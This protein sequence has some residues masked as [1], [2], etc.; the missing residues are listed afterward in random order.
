MRLRVHARVCGHDCGHNSKPILTKLGSVVQDP[1]SKNLFAVFL[2]RGKADD[3][4]RMRRKF[5]MLRIGILAKNGKCRLS[6]KRY[7]IDQKC[8][9]KANRKSGM[10]FR[11]V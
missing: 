1:K 3:F 7:E 2:N 11:M 5:T 8:V 9:W 6:L 10:A 4:M